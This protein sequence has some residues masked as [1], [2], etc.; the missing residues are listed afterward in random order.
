MIRQIIDYVKYDIGWIPFVCAFLMLDKNLAFKIPFLYEIVNLILFVIPLYLMSRFGL[1][2]LDKLTFGFLIISLLSLLLNN[3]N[4]V[5]HAYERLMLFTL[6]LLSFSPLLQSDCAREFRAKVFVM[7]LWGAVLISVISFFCYFL[8]INYMKIE[9]GSYLLNKA[10]TFG[11]ITTQSMALGPISGI[12]TLFMTYQALETSKKI[13]WLCAALCAASVLFAA[14]RSA[15]IATVI[16]ELAIVYTYSSSKTVVLKKIVPI[17]LI[18]CVSYPLWNSALDGLQKKNHSELSNGID[19]ASRANKWDSR[20]EEFKDSPLIG[21]GFVTVSERDYYD[22]NTGIIEPGSSW[23]ATLSM[24]GILGFIVFCGM[25][26]RGIHR[27]LKNQ[28][29]ANR[30]VGCIL[31]LLGI[32]MIA[33]GHIFS[34]GAFLCFMVWITIGVAT[35][36]RDIDIQDLLPKSMFFD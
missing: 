16:G 36:S 28:I 22:V 23:L 6:L 15:F 12:A 19:I 26:F 4:P 3:V 8:G 33:E 11:G 21:I 34:A 10:G 5:F 17:V 27:T 30:M 20:L 29:K 24:T 25:Y 2:K 35:D 9:G 14:S 18:L 31:I 1:P 32:H 7:V 13:Y